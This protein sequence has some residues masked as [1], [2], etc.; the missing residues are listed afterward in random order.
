M[1][2]FE[3]IEI[4]RIFDI[5][6]SK[7]LL[8]TFIIILFTLLGYVYS[9]YYVIPEY[10]SKSTLLLTSEED[11]TT[12]TSDLNLNSGLISTYSNIAKDSRV[13]KQVINNLNLEMTE[14]QL[15]DKIKINIIKNTYVIEVSVTDT[16]PQQA[17]DITK[18]LSNVFL[19]EIKELYNLENIGIVDEAQMPIQPYNINHL[20]D[21][22]L[23][24][25]IGI[26]TVA[27]LIIT[28]YIFDN[29]IKKEDDIE[30]YIKIKALGTVPINENKNEEIVNKN[31]AKSYITEHLNTIRTNIL[32]MNSTKNDKTVLITS[33]TPQEGK[34]WISA[35]ISVSFAE[36]DKKILLIDADMR[37]GRS[38]KIFNI[39]NKVG[40]SD[41]LYSMT[42]DIETDI[43]LL[44]EYI[45]ETKIPNLHILT[46]GSIPPN[47]SELLNSSNMKELIKILKNVYDIII[48][49]APPCKLVT[50]SIILSTIADSTILVANSEK[51]KINDLNEVKKSIQNVGGEIIGV[52]LNKVKATEKTY[53]KGYY[54][55]HSNDTYEIKEKEIITVDSILNEAILKLKEKDFNISDEENIFEDLQEEQ[56]IENKGNNIDKIIKKQNQ[57][58][59]KVS[60]TISD[61]KV[62]LN[63]NTLKNELK[64]RNDKTKMEKILSEKIEEMQQKSTTELKELQEKNNSELKELQEKNSNE[65]KQLQERSSTEI[66]ELQELQERNSSELK[67]LQEKNSNELKQLQE[68]NSTEIKELQE[69]QERNNSEL[70]ELQEKNTIELKE[71]QERNKI[72]WQELQEKN[73]IELRNFQKTSTDEIAELKQ[74]ITN[75]IVT[76]EQVQEILEATNKNNVTKEQVQEILEATNKN[77][78]TKEQVQEVLEATNKN[79]ITKEQIREIL[80]ATNR[81]NITKEQVQEILEE[82]LNKN[83]ISIEQISQ[84]LKENEAN[85]LTIEQ[86]KELLLEEDRKNTLY[87]E[88]IK[89]I[90]R[91]EIVRNTNR[92]EQVRGILQEEITNITYSNQI[93]KLYNEIADMKNNYNQMQNILKQEISNINYTEQIER[94]NEMMSNLKD[95]YL[96]LSNMIR[97]KNDIIETEAIDNTNIINIKTLKKQKEKTHKIKEYSIEEEIPYEELE[98]NAICIIPL[99]P[100]SK[101]NFSDKNYESMM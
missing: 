48:I 47:P 6:K 89:E 56:V 85:M 91:E 96:E 12:T 2:E 81:N 45:K 25:A 30:K 78:V 51:T 23:F 34:S 1:G 90:F 82:K 94:I 101:S 21:I 73:T 58:L 16:N 92:I 17:M 76:K 79:N 69:L 77:N 80:E 95:S 99:N 72:E 28:I 15:K 33:C 50:D 29:T 70:K 14:K 10:K 74:N 97:T 86:I 71:L 67:E 83:T 9:Y 3:N 19:K 41:Y 66:K 54:Y 64:D 39:D 84:T 87:I 52:I 61:I 62:Q 93:D 98:K 57:Y 38:N 5:L 7:K 43:E 24:F 8:I 75:R 18:E 22:A 100:N 59:K 68:R 31:N 46:N 26:F 49:D 44:R 53:S 37:K 65:L 60:D 42:G 40:L 88:Q 27:I 20:K 36:T 32:Y 55:V 11:T 63:S 13:L 35:N 4:K